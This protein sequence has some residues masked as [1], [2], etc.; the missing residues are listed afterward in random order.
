MSYTRSESNNTFSMNS[1]ALS[2]AFN[3]LLHITP[4]TNKKP[5]KVDARANEGTDK[6]KSSTL[7]FTFT[8]ETQHVEKQHLDEFANQSAAVRL[9]RTKSL[10][11]L[12]RIVGP[13]V[14]VHP[15]Y[16]NLFVDLQQYSLGAQNDS[17]AN[18]SR[19]ALTDD[20]HF[21]EANYSRK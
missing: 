3:K 12:E 13:S 1:S 21:Y 11:E 18:Y 15:Q 9:V 2:S 20:I 14:Y 5:Q 8:H 19:E 7:H 16:R 4:I 10:L 17:F 6:S